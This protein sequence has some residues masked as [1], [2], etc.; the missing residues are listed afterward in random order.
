MVYQIRHT[1]NPVKLDVLP[2]P[3]GW[4]GVCPQL[5]ILAG[6]T[7]LD[8]LVSNFSAL[9]AA[10]V[11][12]ERTI[13]SSIGFQQHLERMR[14]AIMEGGDSAESYYYVRSLE[15]GTGEVFSVA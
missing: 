14:G 5:G 11:P 1:P 13:Y 2:T 10:T 4:V 8:D 12:Q 3:E 15:M 6:G 7:T 9:I